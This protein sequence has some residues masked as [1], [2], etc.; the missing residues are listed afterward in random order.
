MQRWEND[1]HNKAAHGVEDAR[2]GNLVEIYPMFFHIFQRIFLFLVVSVSKGISFQ[3]TLW[4][5]TTLRY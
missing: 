1:Q 4:A 3:S 2:Q 5:V